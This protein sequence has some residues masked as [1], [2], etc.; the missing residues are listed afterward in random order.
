MAKVPGVGQVAEWFKAAVLKT[1]EGLG[2]KAQNASISNKKQ[3]RMARN[4]RNAKRFAMAQMSA[5]KNGLETGRQSCPSP[6]QLNVGGSH[7]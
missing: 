7:G 3:P 1:L 4:P 6:H 2:A 5:H